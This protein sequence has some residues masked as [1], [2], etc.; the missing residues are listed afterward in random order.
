[1]HTGGIPEFK[2]RKKLQKEEQKSNNRKVKA[3]VSRAKA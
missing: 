3:F 1:M 2:K